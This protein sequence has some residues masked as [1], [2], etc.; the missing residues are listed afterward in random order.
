VLLCEAL[1]ATREDIALTVFERLFAE[2]G[3]P[4]AIRSNNGV[5]FASQNPL[6][7]LSKLSVWWL[8]LGIQIE[9]IKPGHPQQNG[10]HERMHLTL[11]KEARDRRVLTACFV[12]GRCHPRGD[13]HHQETLLERALCSAVS[14][15]RGD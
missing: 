8:R 9:R 13:D 10:R 7:N 6:F 12:P 11:K 15:S 2:R 3:L 14:L 5:P 1:E 4:M